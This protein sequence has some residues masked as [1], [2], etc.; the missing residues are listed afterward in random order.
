MQR[1][2]RVARLQLE[3]LYEE[4]RRVGSSSLVAMDRRAVER[5]HELLA[6]TRSRERD[7]RRTPRR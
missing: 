5:V 1:L 4:T 2:E 3:R 6:L 7:A